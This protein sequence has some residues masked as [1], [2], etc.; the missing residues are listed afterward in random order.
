MVMN[1][2]PAPGNTNH[3]AGPGGI[4]K[5]MQGPV[6][7]PVHIELP[8][9]HSDPRNIFLNKG[10]D[11]NMPDHISLI[12]GGDSGRSF[13]SPLI[14]LTAAKEQKTELAEDTAPK[15]VEA[16]VPQTL[17]QVLLDLVPFVSVSAVSSGLFAL[18]ASAAGE[19]VAWPAIIGALTPTAALSFLALLALGTNDYSAGDG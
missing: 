5:Y 8:D 2:K 10:G 4:T 12:E 17:K 19:N 16:A 3:K 11:S 14:D 6:R 15:Q 13:E 7:T 18:I 9:R 1:H